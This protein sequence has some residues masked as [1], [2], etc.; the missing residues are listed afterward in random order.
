MHV[1]FD[2]SAKRGRQFTLKLDNG[3]TLAG[4]SQQ[5]AIG[6]LQ[7]SGHSIREAGIVVAQAKLAAA[8]S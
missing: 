1:I 4:V 2:A 8:A 7:A 5:T 6:A 3:K